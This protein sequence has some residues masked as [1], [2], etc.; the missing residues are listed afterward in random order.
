M[1]TDSREHEREYGTRNTIPRDTRLGV[2]LISEFVVES[3]PVIIGCIT[4][5]AIKR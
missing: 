3:A 5:E 2:A 4:D 1:R